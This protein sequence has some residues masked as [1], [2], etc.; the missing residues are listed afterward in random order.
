MELANPIKG[1]DFIDAVFN[2]NT[3]FIHK[4]HSV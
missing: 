3:V 1:F 2:G 4:E